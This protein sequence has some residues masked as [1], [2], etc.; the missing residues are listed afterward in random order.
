MQVGEQFSMVLDVL[1]S[2]KGDCLQASPETGEAAH[3][4]QT[5]KL[6]YDSCTAHDERSLSIGLLALTLTLTC[7]C[8]ATFRARHDMNDPEIKAC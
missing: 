1:P 3:G 4:S 7:S 6:T 2:L 8:L 5:G